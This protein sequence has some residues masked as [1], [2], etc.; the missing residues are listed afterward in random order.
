[1]PR[2]PGTERSEHFAK[3]A[4]VAL[5]AMRLRAL[6]RFATATQTPH[7]ARVQLHTVIALAAAGLV[8]V[9][10]SPNAKRRKPVMVT[11]EGRKQL[12][13]ANFLAPA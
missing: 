9:M 3:P 4:N 12:G 5:D 1:M 13:N 10:G 2:N 6:K 11:D 8:E 7:E